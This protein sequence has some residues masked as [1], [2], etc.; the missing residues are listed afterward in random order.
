[1]GSFR[2]GDS[3]GISGL[4]TSQSCWIFGRKFD[5]ADDLLALEEHRGKYVRWEKELL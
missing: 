1:V 4:R 5:V 3:G 2:S